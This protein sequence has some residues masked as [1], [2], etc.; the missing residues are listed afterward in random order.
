MDNGIVQPYRDG[1]QTPFHGN[2]I[3]YGQHAT[4][5]CC[6]KCIEVWHGILRGREL[7]AEEV[8]YLAELLRAYVTFK[9]PE[10]S[11]RG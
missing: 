2:I 6:R 5:T 10:I 4:A 7:I 11:E 3:Y 8:D 1:T 9:L